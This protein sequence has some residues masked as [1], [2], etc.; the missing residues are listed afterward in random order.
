MI[1]DNY[2]APRNELQRQICKIWSDV[3]GVGQDKIGIQDDFFRLGGDSIISIQLANKMK[4]SLGLTLTVKN[5][6]TYKTIEKL[7]DNLFNKAH[8]DSAK[9]NIKT[10][11]GILGEEVPLLPIQKYFFR[12]NFTVSNHWN[13]SFLIKVPS[14]N[15]DRLRASI[16]E[17]VKFHDAFR[18]RYKF[19]DIINLTTIKQYYDCSAV[20]EEL[21]L[22]DLD[23]LDE[24]EG[25]DGFETKLHGILTQ[26]QSNFDLERGPMYCIGYIYLVT[27][28]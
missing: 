15:I 1:K 2:V 12:N 26:W 28:L 14:L 24:R 25:S 11:Q 23:S 22:L 13:Q 21:K 16:R 4:L 17:L 18:L 6:F 27:A 3:L 9:F 20:T 7:Y 8:E 10:E 19:D 5:I